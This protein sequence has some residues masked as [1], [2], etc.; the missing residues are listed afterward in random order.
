MHGDPCLTGV[1]QH[2]DKLI[3]GYMIVCQ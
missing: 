3:K 2:L 1:P